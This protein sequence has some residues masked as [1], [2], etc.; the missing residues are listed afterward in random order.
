MHRLEIIDYYT[1]KS[2]LEKF[3]EEKLVI[4]DCNSPASYIDI[5]GGDM[6]IKML[7]SDLIKDKRKALK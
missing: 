6:S 3:I 1:F 4:L 7:Y 5:E 2:I